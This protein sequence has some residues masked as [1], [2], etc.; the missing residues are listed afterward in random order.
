MRVLVP[1]PRPTVRRPSLRWSR[2]LRL[3][4]NCTG[5]RR[6][7]TKTDAPMRTRSVSAETYASSPVGSS[8]AMVPVICSATQRSS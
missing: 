7:L 8:D 4:A 3:L 6:V 2:V 1:R 5:F